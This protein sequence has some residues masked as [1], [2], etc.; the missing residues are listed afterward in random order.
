MAINL[1]ENVNLVAV[2]GSCTAGATF[3]SMQLRAGFD[4]E[5]VATWMGHKDINVTRDYLRAIHASKARPRLNTG[6]MAS[7]LN[8]PG[9]DT[10]S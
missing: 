9:K 5:T 4:I 7:L 3:G 2:I 8:V 10:E 1:L 6:L